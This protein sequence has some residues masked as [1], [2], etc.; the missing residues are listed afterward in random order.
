MVK[1]YKVLV[2]EDIRREWDSIKPGLYYIHSNVGSEWRPED[3]YTA[4]QV[5]AAQL[6]IDQQTGGF[7]ILQIKP[8][9]FG[10]GKSLL[11][12]VAY[13]EGGD[14]VAE[15]LP[16]LEDMARGWGCDKVE[17]WSSRRG[18]ERLVRGSGYQISNIIYTK[19]L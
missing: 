19:D 7:V 17:F 2:Q 10:G 18:M 6:W 12:W 15:Y 11:I 16:E 5:G 4:V 14:G 13:Y 1:L 3:I 9:A 8:D